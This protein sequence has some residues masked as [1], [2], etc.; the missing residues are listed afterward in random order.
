MLLREAIDFNDI[1]PTMFL[2][3]GK[4][5]GRVAKPTCRTQFLSTDCPILSLMDDDTVAVG[6]FNDRPKTYSRFTERRVD[7]N[8]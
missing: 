3:I 1:I 6:V 2:N 4:N 8:I 5:R 7:P